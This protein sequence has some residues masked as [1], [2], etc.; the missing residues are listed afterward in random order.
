MEH[1]G[2]FGDWD[3]S[4]SEYESTESD[5]G[6]EASIGDL[7][8]EEAV[9]DD[10]NTKKDDIEDVTTKNATSVIINKEESS[11][12]EDINVSSKYVNPKIPPTE[13]AIVAES[14]HQEREE[15]Q[16]IR[17]VWSHNLREEFHYICHLVKKLTEVNKNCYVALDTEY[18]GVVHEPDFFEEEAEYGYQKVKRNVDSLKLIQLGITLFDSNGVLPDGVCTWQFNFQFDYEVDQNAQS[19]MDLLTRAG[20]VFDNHKSYGIN[21]VEFAELFYGSGLVLS[22]NVIWITFHSSYDF[23][24]MLRQLLQRDLPST[25]QDF[26]DELRL[27][28]P[29]IYD[30]RRITRLSISLQSLANQLQVVRIGRQHQAGSDSLLTGQVFFS[31]CKSYFPDGVNFFSRYGR[32]LTSYRG[33]IYGL[34]PKHQF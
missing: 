24:Y 2:S 8:T 23:A 5:S 30:I 33:L 21:H 28:F 26:L 20:I 13:D 25:K 3:T 1:W 22:N 4:D 15:V 18:P 34:E 19:S 17:E 6:L 7:S 9:N 14:Q 11:N 32:P 12:S 31:Y 29:E 27:Y 10:V 16:R